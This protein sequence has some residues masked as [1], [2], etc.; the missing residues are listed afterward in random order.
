MLMQLYQG[1]TKNATPLLEIYLK[2]RLKRGKEDPART[3]ERRG[4]A[5]KLREDKPLV[6]FHAASVGESQ[7][8][9]ILIRQMLADYPGIQVMVTTGTVT[10]AKLMADRLPEKE[11]PGRA[12]HQ[13]MPVDQPD[14]TESFLNYWHPD[15]IVWS[16]SEFWPNMLAGIRK[17]KIPAVLLNARMSEKSFQRWQMA[18]GMISE[19]LQAFRLCLGQSAAEASRLRQLGASETRVSSN[20]KYASAPLPY[21][22]ARLEEL[23][24]AVGSRPLVL[25]AQTHPGEE[26][27]ACRVHRQLQ[28][29]KPDLLTIIVPR[30][31]DRGAA[32]SE[33]IAR[34][35]VK[36]SRRSLPQ[37]PQKD[38]QVYIADTMG[39]LG[40]FYRLCR[41]CV[42]AGSFTWGGH[43]P[44]EPGQLGCEIFY[45][46]HMFNFETIAADFESRG[47]AVRAAD[48]VELEKNLAQALQDPA[49]FSA[50]GQAAK[51]W[52]A[53][54][55]DAAQEISAVLAPFMKEI[56]AC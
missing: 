47:A 10:S 13:Y 26:E 46:P 30:H 37:L 29:V 54:H 38:D 41:L 1:L 31:P 14:W 25:W 19:L 24:A 32:I 18:R 52:T 34:T 3:A 11:F 23:K 36:T 2:R 6:W 5:S 44:I 28:R 8:L 43:N 16:E 17:R 12:F 7:A 40:L 27:I 9:L 42:V 15:F 35:G 33:M 20:L 22:A 4:R 21:D 39:E 49:H 55:A 56:V 50:L 45:G 51:A 53:Q 48:E